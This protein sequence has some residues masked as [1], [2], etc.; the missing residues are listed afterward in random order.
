M[1]ILA[2]EK[3]TNLAYTSHELPFHMDLTFYES[4]PGLLFLHCIRY[5]HIVV[6]VYTCDKSMLG[7]PALLTYT[8]VKIMAYYLVIIILYIVV[9]FV[10][11]RSTWPVY[12][13][14][15]MTTFFDITISLAKICAQDSL[16]FS[17]TAK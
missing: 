8:L 14:G 9:V 5:D 11:A 15:Q 16:D 12:M 3:P 13:G 6:T 4:P 2:E 10:L 17:L 7:E 1:E